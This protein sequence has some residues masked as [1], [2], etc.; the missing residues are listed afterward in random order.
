MSVTDC[1]GSCGD[2]EN[3]PKPR[4]AVVLAGLMSE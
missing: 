1:I 4:A 2:N 3:V